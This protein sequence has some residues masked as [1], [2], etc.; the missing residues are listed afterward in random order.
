MMEL[1]SGEYVQTQ[2]GEVGKVIL[3]DRLTVFVSFATPSLPHDIRAFLKSE[4]TKID[5]PS[6]GESP[7][8]P[9]DTED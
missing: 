2:T 6:A 4:L 5:P 8:V 9:R 1:M 7:P 3:I